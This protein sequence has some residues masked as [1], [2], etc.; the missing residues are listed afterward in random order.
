MLAV[1]KDIHFCAD[2]LGGND[3]GVLWHVS[4]S[5]DLSLMID[6]LYHLDLACCNA[7]SF[8]QCPSSS[9]TEDTGTSSVNSA[10]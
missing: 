8:C 5:V 9:Y 10:R 2:C 6:L 4:C 7:A 1:V 3:E